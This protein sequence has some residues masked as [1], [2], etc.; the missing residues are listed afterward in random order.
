M[1]ITRL[2]VLSCGCIV[3]INVIWLF[4]TVLWVGLQCVIVVIPD[5]THLL[6]YAYYSQDNMF[7]KCMDVLQRSMLM[8]M[9]VRCFSKHDQTSR[10]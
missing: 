2:L 5:H 1:C 10:L 4:L 3:A 7:Y 6:F 9:Q 8:S